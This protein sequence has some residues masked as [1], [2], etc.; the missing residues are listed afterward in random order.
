[1][2]R[3]N[4]GGMDGLEDKPKQDASDRHEEG[5]NA[6]GVFGIYVLLSSR[7]IWRHSPIFTC[8]AFGPGDEKGTGKDTTDDRPEDVLS[9]GTCDDT[10]TESTP[11]RV[12]ELFWIWLPTRVVSENQLVCTKSDEDAS[13][14]TEPESVPCPGGEELL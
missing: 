12:G 5:K 6:S 3:N 2:D 8:G 10:G 1:V 7:P 11:P 9:A 4:L 13:S 14:E